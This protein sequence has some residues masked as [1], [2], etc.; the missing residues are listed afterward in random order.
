MKVGQSTG[1]VAKWMTHT[2][3]VKQGKGPYC[4]NL[5][6][7]QTRDTHFGQRNS[8]YNVCTVLFKLAIELHKE[9][10]MVREKIVSS[11]EEFV[12]IFVLIF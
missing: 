2:C 7:P 3:P 9:K 4:L 5:S 8:Q 10:N 12:L 11:P 1:T 6:V